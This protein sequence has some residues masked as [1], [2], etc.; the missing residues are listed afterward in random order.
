[1][2]IEGAD[3][4]AVYA[5][6]VSTAAAGWQVWERRQRRIPQVEVE[7]QNVSSERGPGLWLDVR[8]RGEYPARVT[9]ITFR[10]HDP[11]RAYAALRPGRFS[12]VGKPLPGLAI[13]EPGPGTTLPG[14]IEPHGAG[15]T[16]VA[17]SE[18]ERAG[19]DLSKPIRAA[20][21]VATGERFATRSARLRSKNS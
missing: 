21:L 14:V 16:V 15:Y 1:M 12:R 7:L 8:N 10:N 17:T 6:I 5:A 9:L 11:R 19:V 2:T 18:L 20:V 13:T 4:I 3:P